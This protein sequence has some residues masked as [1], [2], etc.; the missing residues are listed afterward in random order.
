MADATAPG[1]AL[2]SYSSPNA[3]DSCSV[4]SVACVAASGSN[5]PSGT[6]T[7]Q[8][9]VSDN[10]NHTASCGFTVKVKSPAEQAADLITKINGWP[11]VQG[12]T[13]NSFTSKLEAAIA[14][15]T[16]G[17]TKAAC[18]DLGA[19]MNAVQA[20]AG[21]GISAAQAADLLADI[22]RIRGALGCS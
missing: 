4:R 2:V 14:R 19:L 5:F 21:K 9:T 22:T 13:K 15:M 18:N 16:A 10:A 11:G 20:Q 7:V 17:N 6:S 8:C 1:G 3:A 12:G